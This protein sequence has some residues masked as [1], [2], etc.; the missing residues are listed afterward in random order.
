MTHIKYPDE[1]GRP[2]PRGP[3]WQ[4]PMQHQ[5]NWQGEAMH[6]SALLHEALTR[7]EA[8]EDKLAKAVVALHQMLEDSEYWSPY[9]RATLARLEEK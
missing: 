5:A 8:A 4:K 6:L 1:L 3:D 2:V 9:A 7:V